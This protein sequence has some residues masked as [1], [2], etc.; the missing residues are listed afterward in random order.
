MGRA[1]RLR[2][3]VVEHVGVNIVGLALNLVCPTT[4]VPY[5][6][7]DGTDITTGHVDGLAIV[8][9]LDSSQQVCVLLEQIGQLQQQASPLGGGSLL[10]RA[11]ECLA[12]GSYGQ[13]DI[14]LVTLVNLG[15]NLLGGGVD[16]V[17]LLLVDRLDPLAVNVPEKRRK[18][19]VPVARE[20]QV[21]VWGDGGRGTHKP[22]GCL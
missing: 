17:E 5:A 6:A 11:L 10:P 4:I 22:M 1:Y 21:I 9:R 12:G 13:V 20:E 16:N 19:L 2:P 3:G 18:V 15:D 14:L 7:N 8:E